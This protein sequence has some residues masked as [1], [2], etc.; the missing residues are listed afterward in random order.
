MEVVNPCSVVFQHKGEEPLLV[1][2][3]GVVVYNGM[4]D[5]MRQFVYPP[6]QT[7]ESECCQLSDNPVFLF[8]GDDQMAVQRNAAEGCVC[9]LQPCAKHCENDEQAE[10]EPVSGGEALY[11]VGG[12]GPGVKDA[13]GFLELVAVGAPLATAI[14]SAMH[15]C[16]AGIPP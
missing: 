5:V 13:V 6:P 15:G 2:A 4:V 11:A 16:M 12:R 9:R 10:Q 8:S 3:Y 7:L 1:P 14:F